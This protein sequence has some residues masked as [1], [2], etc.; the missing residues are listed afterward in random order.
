MLDGYSQGAAGIDLI[1]VPGQAAFGLGDP[2]P[3]SIAEDVAAVA[4]FGNPSNRMGAY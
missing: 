2:L 4:V 1:T 3:E